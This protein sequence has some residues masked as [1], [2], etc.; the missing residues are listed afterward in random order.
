MSGYCWDDDFEE[1]PTL[2]LEDEEIT[3][4]ML[5]LE[6]ASTMRP[7]PF[8]GSKGEMAITYDQDGDEISFRVKCHCGG[9][10]PEAPQ[11]SQAVWSWNGFPE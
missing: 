2:D 4:P 1:Q 11:I 9:Q 8:C 6:P 5:D 7:C 10:G 3:D